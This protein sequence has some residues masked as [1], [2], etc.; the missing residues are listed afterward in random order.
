[1][2]RQLDPQ[3]C[4]APQ[5]S[6]P[7]AAS[8]L[9][10]PGRVPQ[11]AFRAPLQ[12]GPSLHPWATWPGKA[13]CCQSQFRECAGPSVTMTLR[14]RPGQR[15]PDGRAQWGLWLVYVGMT[16][17]FQSRFWFFGRPI[18]SPPRELSPSPSETK[19][20]QRPSNSVLLAAGLQGK[21][22]GNLIPGRTEM[23]WAKPLAPSFSKNLPLEPGVSQNS[24][25]TYLAA[26][27]P[28]STDLH[29]TSTSSEVAS[30]APPSNNTAAS[31]ASTPPPPRSN[32]FGA[33]QGPFARPDRAPPTPAVGTITLGGDPSPC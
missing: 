26:S 9:N 13:C 19:A 15:R 5:A 25:V 33:G 10:T 11:S 28:R 4:P 24:A 18:R 12:P 32:S 7:D 27:V 21:L 8:I 17:A 3:L 23:C 14:N 1:M 2:G 31:T 16:T 6:L 30:T 29:H 22:E 20:M